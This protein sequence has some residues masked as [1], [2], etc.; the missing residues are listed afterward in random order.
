[1]KGPILYKLESLRGIAA[2]C[3]L[4]HHA[5]QPIFS[6]AIPFLQTSWLFVDLFFILSGFVM[7][8]AYRSKVWSGLR[9]SEYFSARFWRLYPLH[10]VMLLLFLPLIA[11]KYWFYHSGYGGTDPSLTENW[12][13]FFSE[14]TLTKTLNYTPTGGWNSVSWSISAEFIAYIAFFGL[15]RVIR[16]PAALVSVSLALALVLYA[17]GFLWF[18]PFSALTVD[19]GFLRSIPGFLIGVALYSLYRRHQFSRQMNLHE[20]FAV[21]MAIVSVSLTYYRP[22]FAYLSLIGFTYGIYVFSSSKS[23]WIGRLL[24]TRVPK[25]L[26]KHSYSI[27][28]THL[29]IMVGIDDFLAFVLKIPLESITGVYALLLNL[30]VITITIGLSVLTYRFIED[31]FRKKRFTA[32]GQLKLLF[33]KRFHA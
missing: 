6:W 33:P 5:E 4:L 1:M 7:T 18:G 22:E 29:L 9:F 2:I 10:L 20:I 3:V 30:F 14:I 31:P 16:T 12:T 26:G 11:F 15:L 27:Y 28:M 13:S 8:L 32:L 19:F 25:F 23:G 21:G 17:L 24:E